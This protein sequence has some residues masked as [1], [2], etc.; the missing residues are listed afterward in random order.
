M[1]R[2]SSSRH[3]R[4]DRRSIIPFIIVRQRTPLISASF[5]MG[6]GSELFHN[7]FGRGGRMG[8]SIT[9]V[10]GILVGHAHDAVRGSGVTVLLFPGGAMAMADIRGEAAGTRQMDSLLRPHPSRKS[11]PSSLPRERIRSRRGI[12]SCLVPRSAQSRVLHPGGYRPH[13]SHSGRLRPG[14]RG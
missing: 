5:H 10:A 1:Y 11:M 13:C 12:G 6:I 2:P 3:L 7:V 9:E 4:F 8:G 14:L